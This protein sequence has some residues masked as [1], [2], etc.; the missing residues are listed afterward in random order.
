MLWLGQGHGRHDGQDQNYDVPHLR[1]LDQR[2]VTGSDSRVL[3]CT[4]AHGQ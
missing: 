2:S 4:I 3:Y 1:G